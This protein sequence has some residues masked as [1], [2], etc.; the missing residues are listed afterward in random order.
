ML[1]LTKHEER[2]FNIVRASPLVGL[3]MRPSYGSAIEA[4]QKLFDM[5]LTLVGTG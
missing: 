2:S 5:L 4:G 1:S 3:G